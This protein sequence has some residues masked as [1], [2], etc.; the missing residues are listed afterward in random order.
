MTKHRGS[1]FN[2]NVTVLILNFGCTCSDD[3]CEIY[4][5]TSKILFSNSCSTLMYIGSD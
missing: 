2:A 4:S 5:C 1:F 3:Y